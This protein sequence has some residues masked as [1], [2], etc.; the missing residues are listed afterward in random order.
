MCAGRC[1][2]PSRASFSVCRAKNLLSVLSSSNLAPRNSPLSAVDYDYDNDNDI[3]QDLAAIALAASG[4]H[5]AEDDR[6]GL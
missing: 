1:A 2:Y 6:F 3:E 5:M 4:I